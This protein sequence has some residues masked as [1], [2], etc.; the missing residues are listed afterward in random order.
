MQQLPLGQ[1]VGVQDQLGPDP[2]M[3]LN[4][5]LDSFLNFS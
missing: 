2:S 5:G 1:E 3:A 4:S